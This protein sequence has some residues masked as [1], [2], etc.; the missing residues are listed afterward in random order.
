MKCLECDKEFTPKR[1]TAQFCSPYCRVKYNRKK[2]AEDGDPSTSHVV[3]LKKKVKERILAK[4]PPS[5]PVHSITQSELEKI[6]KTLVAEDK[7]NQGKVPTYWGGAQL[8]VENHGDANDLARQVIFSRVRAPKETDL[9][10]TQLPQ[11]KS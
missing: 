6:R 11:S 3:E 10:K 4:T 2:L 9:P 7:A 5:A 1:S 8:P